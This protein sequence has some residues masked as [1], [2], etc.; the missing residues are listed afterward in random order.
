MEEKKARHTKERK[1]GQEYERKKNWIKKGEKKERV[2]ENDREIK[3]PP[4]NSRG[5][6]NLSTLKLSEKTLPY[7]PSCYH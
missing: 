1:E 2:R 6:S 4:D 7:F 3:Q 5:K